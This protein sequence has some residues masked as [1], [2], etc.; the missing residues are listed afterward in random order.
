MIYN[1]VN[2]NPCDDKTVHA[3]NRT[4]LCYHVD[5]NKV[6]VIAIFIDISL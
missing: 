5:A 4:L 3:L 2:Q 1:K 6:I